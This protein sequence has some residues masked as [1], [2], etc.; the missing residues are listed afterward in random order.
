MESFQNI[1]AGQHL[2]ISVLCNSILVWDTSPWRDKSLLNQNTT[3][4][5]TKGGH[6]SLV[7]TFIAEN[8]LC[9]KFHEE[10]G[11]V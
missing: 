8:I 4:G 2:S 6:H 3:S 5:V 1:D 10:M 11:I 9:L 7:V